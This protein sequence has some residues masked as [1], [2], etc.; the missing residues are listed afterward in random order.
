MKI[1]IE[2]S[3]G[4][5]GLTKTITVDTEDLPSEMADNI[6]KHLADTKS[7]SSSTVMSKKKRVADSYFYRISGQLG[8]KKQEIE[9]NESDVDDELK[10]F[11]DYVFRN[12]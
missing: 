9:L 4:F 8:K 1:E 11:I 10:F 7:K 2:R 12:Y 5:A 6:K 3:G